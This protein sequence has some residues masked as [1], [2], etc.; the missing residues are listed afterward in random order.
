MSIKN[1]P[2][3]SEQKVIEHTDMVPRFHSYQGREHGFAFQQLRRV[4][5]VVR[6]PEQVVLPEPIL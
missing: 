1:E 2:K 6:R 5:Q 3:N 4:L